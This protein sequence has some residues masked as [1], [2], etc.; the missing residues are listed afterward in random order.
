MFKHRWFYWLWLVVLCLLLGLIDA[1]RSYGS[2][3]YNGV[4]RL[5][6]WI[7][8]RWDLSGWI[9]WV[10]LIPLIMRLCDRLPIDR[11][12]WPSRMLIFGP[13]GLFASSIR[14]LFPILVHLIIEPDFS[15]MARWLSPKPYF[16]LTDFLFGLAFYGFVLAFG[17]A[18]NYYRRYREEELRRSHLEA[19]LARA[20]LRA[21]KMQLHPHFLFN[22]LH[23]ISAL[24]LEDVAAAQKMMSRLGDFLRMTLENAGLQVVPLRRE[25][26]FLKCYLD[27][28]QIRF[29]RRLT[30]VIEVEPE[31]LEAPA[32]NLILQPLVENAIRHGVAPRP[33][34][35][36]IRVSAKR[37][38]GR[39]KVVISDNGCGLKQN[40]NGASSVRE[41]LGL[42]NTRARLWQI[43]GSDFGFDLVN[44]AEGG[45]VVTLDLPLNGHLAE[46][47]NGAIG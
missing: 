16:L 5:E 37:E 12:N 18:R 15:E 30:T 27:I 26:D 13:L 34:D 40:G 41:G 45:L 20:E 44:G 1:L 8:L 25:I 11:E 36:L 39:L 47:V 28:E 35:G 42:Q 6:W 32:P 33:A 21:L 24:Q 29:G 43:Y 19:Q 9:V 22:T 10:P 38:R 17:Q 2:A 46:S 7:A 14:A 3:Y 4:Y 23:S 31:A